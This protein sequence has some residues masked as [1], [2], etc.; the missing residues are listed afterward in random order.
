[1]RPLPSGTGSK[2]F[3]SCAT[4][5]MVRTTAKA[6]TSAD[7]EGLRQSA[8]A[9]VQ[10]RAAGDHVVL[11]HREAADG[12]GPKD[13][14]CG[15]GDRHVVAFRHRPISPDHADFGS[16]RRVGEAVNG[17]RTCCGPDYVVGRPHRPAET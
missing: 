14:R 2:A 6:A 5:V 12:G 17:H 7:W 9:C 11:H 15:E 13:G 4:P 3:A 1:M 16:F 10:G 8:N